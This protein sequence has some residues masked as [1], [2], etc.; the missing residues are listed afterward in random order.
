MISLLCF[1]QQRIQD[2][3]KA[4]DFQRGEK[5]MENG[6]KS[7]NQ[8]ASL[9]LCF[10]LLIG[11]S[12]YRI[13]PKHT[14]P[15]VP[16]AGYERIIKLHNPE[17]LPENSLAGIVHITGKATVCTDYPRQEIINSLDDLSLM[18]KLAYPY[19]Q[20]YAVK[21]GAVI[22]GYV[23][24]AIDYRV[25]IWRNENAPDCRYKIQIVMPERSF[26]SPERDGVDKSIT[27]W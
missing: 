10:L 1:P 24:V 19:L 3:A 17:G 25:N 8:A 13:I 14:V 15:G 27:S 21:D 11:C 5:L 18:E 9:C 7:I 4:A 26:G 2:K 6:I 22:F 20:V 23:S 12:G 16:D